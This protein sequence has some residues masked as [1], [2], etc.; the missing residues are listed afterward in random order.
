M[1]RSCS[2]SLCLPLLCN[3]TQVD[4]APLELLDFNMLGMGVCVLPLHALLL[5]LCVERCC[6]CRYSGN[7]RR[8]VV[9][10][11]QA[12]GRKVCHARCQCVA[13]RA[14]AVHCNCVRSRWGLSLLWIQ[15][16]WSRPQARAC[17][18][19]MHARARMWKRQ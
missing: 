16:C 6:C 1:Q 19:P 4:A 18:L 8:H 10:L 13:V 7:Q 12:Q 9:R 3:N 11:I 2:S 15:N 14:A 5:V 17:M